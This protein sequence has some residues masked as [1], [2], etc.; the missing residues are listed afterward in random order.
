[1]SKFPHGHKDPVVT[2]TD[3]RRSDY[4]VFLSGLDDFKKEVTAAGLDGKVV[5]LDRGD[6]FKF[7]VKV[8]S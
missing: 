5:Y 7:D 6:A 2:R 1:M 4:D 8:S 3:V